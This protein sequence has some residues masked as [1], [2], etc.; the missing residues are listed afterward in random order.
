MNARKV[1]TKSVENRHDEKLSQ[2]R[3]RTKH[4]ASTTARQA[5]VLFVSQGAIHSTFLMSTLA[6]PALCITLLHAVPDAVS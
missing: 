3:A 2:E 6:D 5:Y 4:K 1:I